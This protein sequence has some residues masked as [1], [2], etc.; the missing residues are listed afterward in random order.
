MNYNQVL[1][2]AEGPHSYS[3]INITISGN[4]HNTTS[5]NG[6]LL[7]IVTNT[8]TGSGIGT[9]T[10]PYSKFF[11]ITA[12]SSGDVTFILATDFLHRGFGGLP[13]NVSATVRIHQGVVT[14]NLYRA[15]DV[16]NDGNVGI[17]DLTEV[18][19][20]Q[21]ST[22][23]MRDDVAGNT[24]LSNSCNNTVDITDMVTVYANQFVPYYY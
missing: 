9:S 22:T 23:Q 19:N 2:W 21:F 1:R 16:N 15:L 4:L 20:N 18:H 7:L 10:N 17:D 11:T 14:I 24:Q 3:N 5:I 6:N 8:T 12:P 13:Y